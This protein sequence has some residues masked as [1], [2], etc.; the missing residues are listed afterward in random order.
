MAV[1]SGGHSGMKPL[2]FVGLHKPQHAYQFK[3]CM[4]SINVLERRRSDFTVNDWLLDSGAFTRIKT[5]RGHMLVEDYAR[6]IIRWSQCGNLIAAV[7]Q[8]WMCEPFILKITGLTVKEHQH[9]TVDNFMEL[10]KLVPEDIYIMPVL[11]G[12]TSEEYVAHIHMYGDLL[13]PGMLVGVGSV[14]KR[15]G[16]PK[17]IEAILRAIKD[18]RP[19]LQ[20]H[21]FGLKKTA[22]TSPLVNLY[23]K[24]CDSAGWSLAERMKGGDANGPAGAH[25]YVKALENMPIQ[26]V[27]GPGLL[28]ELSEEYV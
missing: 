24:E 3:R 6:Q 2:F 13:K 16:N 20:L 8:D 5:G 19:D 23:L 18:E 17:A 27:L 28:L 21:G 1:E 9:R 12:Y 4:I 22:L 10:R 15:N 25:R 7:A 26:M 14:C 11:Q